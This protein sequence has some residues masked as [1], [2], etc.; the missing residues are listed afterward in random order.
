MWKFSATFYG[1]GVIGGIGGNVKSNVRHQVMSMKKD[2]S[3]TQDT[4]SFAQRA[5]K[6]VQNTKIKPFY[7]EEIANDKKAN[8][9]A[10]IQR[11]TLTI[12]MIKFK[13]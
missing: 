2:R 10:R 5:Q 9:S 4:E 7:D 3:I 11:C 8:P 13:Q 1:K 6:L 12:L